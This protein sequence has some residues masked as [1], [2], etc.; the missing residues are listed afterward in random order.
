MNSDFGLI[1]AI[2]DAYGNVETSSSGTVKWRSTTTR[3][4]RNW[5]ERSR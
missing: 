5:V 1:A 4:G 2:E 3:A